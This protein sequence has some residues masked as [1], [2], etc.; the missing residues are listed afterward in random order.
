MLHDARY[1]H[2]IKCK[3][4]FNSHLISVKISSISVKKQYSTL[5]AILTSQYLQMNRCIHVWKMM[6][7]SEC[8]INLQ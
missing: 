2:L 8:E 3:L 5:T 1:L 6:C 4:N 7:V